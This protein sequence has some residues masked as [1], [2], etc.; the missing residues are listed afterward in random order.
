[1]RVAFVLWPA[2]AHLFPLVN[3]AW[4]CR[5]AG[6]EVTFLSHP[7][8]A[9]EVT[10][11]GLPFMP[12]CQPGEIPPPKGPAL[13]APESRAAVEEITKALDVPDEDRDRW[14]I[15][16]TGFIP[17]MWD[18]IP[19]AAS[20]SE[21]MPLMDNMVTFF[22]HWHPDL[23]LWD[24][25]MPGAAVAAR[26]AGA[27]QARIYGTDYMGW[28]QDTYARLV[29]L[30]GAPKVP[31]PLA[32]TVRG[33]AERY[34]VPVDHDTLYGQFTVGMMPPGMDFEVDTSKLRMRWVPFNAPSESMPD[35]LYP[36]PDRPRVALSLGMSIRAF[37]KGDWSFTSTLLE[38]LGDLDVEVVAT[39]NAD[40]IA[41]VGT[42]PDNVRVVEYVPL[43]YLIPTCSVLIHHGGLG[44]MAPAAYNGVPQ[45]IVDFSDT[46]FRGAFLPKGAA[47]P[48]SGRP[49]YKL[50]P[51][52]GGY[53]T[54][55][56]AGEII[57]L[58]QTRDEAVDSV[59]E[60][61]T[62]VLKD[63]AYT[64]GAARL[65]RDLLASPAPT[66]VV[67]TLESITRAG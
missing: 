3:L 51:V 23:V 16:T 43:D 34:D 40:Q 35:W 11:C 7:S 17:S 30:P 53:I 48:T 21:P 13:E 36:V 5:S 27:R 46:R 1:M 31:S 8:I 60:Q 41:G 63:P 47:A 56:G 42:M 52:T 14:N 24:P 64:A 67:P 28:F 20:P 15:T 38:G 32:E 57:D 6:H 25:C 26:A 66:D 65:R 19:Y 49:R 10:S 12:L 18:F 59:R 50:A 29:S 44:T 54:S 55:F 22:K 4:A 9:A 39:L 37:L 2:P 58:A 61:V 33:M 45:M 62:R